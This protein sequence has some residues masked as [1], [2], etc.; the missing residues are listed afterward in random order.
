MELRALEGRCR[1][2]LPQPSRPFALSQHL[3]PS[4]VGLLTSTVK[5]EI[6]PYG[7]ALL[8]G[9]TERDSSDCRVQLLGRNGLKESCCSRQAS[10]VS[11]VM[12]PKGATPK[13][14]AHRFRIL[15]D[16][17]VSSSPR[18]RLPEKLFRSNATPERPMLADGRIEH[19]PSFSNHAPIL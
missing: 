2:S 6:C 8:G 13:T 10:R 7:F 16:E 14:W 3:N 4:R 15:K 18:I 9:L 12:E 19:W 1:H 17:K 11:F 5:A